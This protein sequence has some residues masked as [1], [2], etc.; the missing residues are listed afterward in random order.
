MLRKYSRRM[1]ILFGLCLAAWAS[2]AQYAVTGGTGTPLLAKDDTYNDIQVYLVYGMNNVE[3]SY[4]SASASHQWYRYKTA[5]L[6][7]EK[8][9][10]IQNGT[11]S[12]IRNVEEGYGYYVEEADKMKKFVWIIDYSR[13]AFDV[14]S[15][16]VMDTGDPCSSLQLEGQG[17]APYMY[18]YTPAGLKTPLQRVGTVSYH[19]LEWSEESGLFSNKEVVQEMNI[20]PEGESSFRLAAPNASSPLKAPLQDTEITLKG[21]EFARH[22]NVEKTAR[23][24]EYVAVAVELHADTVLVDSEALN[25]SSGNAG[26]SAP[27]TLTFTAVANDPVASLYIWTIY[28]S[29]EG[30]EDHP[31]LRFTGNEVD[32]TFNN[33]G[34]YVARAEVSDRSGVCSDSFEYEIQIAESYLDVP[35]V[36]SPGMS[37]GINDE[38]KVAYKSLVRFKAWIFNRWGQE[39]FHWTDPSKGW[40]GKKGGKYVPPGVYYYVIEAEGSDGLKYKKAGDINILRSKTIQTEIIDD[41]K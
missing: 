17:H 11:T 8:I 21:D 24:A 20:V 30:G 13:Y 36:F 39:L 27:A 9:E 38:F 10:S 1:G 37:P 16:Q 15:L 31:I 12:S 33:A 22:F 35:N 41:T 23:V 26:Y 6:Q 28:K 3:I 25:M 32:Y 40:D 7:S 29:E 14:S 34:K 4:T 18:Y 2:Y 5:Y 19:T